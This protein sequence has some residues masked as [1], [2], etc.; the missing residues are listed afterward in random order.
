M[1]DLHYFIL[2]RTSDQINEISST[3]TKCPWGWWGYG[4]DDNYQIFNLSGLTPPRW[5]SEK[6]LE[7]VACLIHKYTLNTK[8]QNLCLTPFIYP[9]NRISIELGNWREALVHFNNW[10]GSCL[11]SFNPKNNWSEAIIQAQNNIFTEQTSV[12]KQD[13]DSEV[14]KDD[15][16]YISSWLGQQMLI[17]PKIIS[18]IINPLVGINFNSDELT[19]LCVLRK[20]WLDFIRIGQKMFQTRL[21][22]ITSHNKIISDCNEYLSSNS[23]NFIGQLNTK[24]SKIYITYDISSNIEYSKNI[25]QSIFDVFNYMSVVLDL[26]QLN[27]DVFCKYINNVSIRIREYLQKR[28]SKSYIPFLA[29]SAEYNHSELEIAQ[30]NE[31]I[32]CYQN[33][34][35]SGIYSNWLIIHNHLLCKLHES[36]PLDCKLL[37]SCSKEI[38][39][40]GNDIC[41]TLSFTMQWNIKDIFLKLSDN[42]QVLKYIP[43]KNESPSC[44][45][46]SANY[47]NINYDQI[48]YI[49]S[50]FHDWA[51]NFSENMNSENI[52][53]FFESLGYPI[54]KSYTQ[55]NI[56]QIKMLPDLDLSQIEKCSMDLQLLI[57]SYE[58]SIKKDSIPIFRMDQL[59][60]ITQKY[61]K[62]LGFEI[63]NVRH[64]E[65]SITSICVW[66]N[67]NQKEGYNL[68]LSDDSK[69]YLSL[70]NPDISSLSIEQLQEVLEFLDM[71]ADGNIIF[72]VIRRKITDFLA[73]KSL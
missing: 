61:Q 4:L 36:L 38:D 44:S 56:G 21:F 18:S 2:I 40:M 9:S 53:Y 13:I 19:S 58:E 31:T 12:L 52:G 30:V 24:L 59:Y 72:D 57:D 3:L 5:I 67:Y 63:K 32:N 33:N 60:N 71:V 10:L 49:H 28:V 11:K 51:N 6:Q 29:I 55:D 70:S 48:K 45:S 42:I 35:L 46:S 14:N 41:Q 73:S 65:T 62:L 20:T 43:D 1:S 54:I 64:P 23:R 27:F 39:R 26:G 47:N 15:I 34:I 17:N 22:D 37:L 66:K 69:Y 8:N 16:K 7:K 68:L 50:I 25:S